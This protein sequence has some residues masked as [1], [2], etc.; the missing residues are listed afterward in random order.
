MRKGIDGIEESG[1]EEDG[2]DEGEEFRGVLRRGPNLT[3]LFIEEYSILNH[4]R[5]FAFHEECVNIHDPLWVQHDDVRRGVL[6]K[7]NNS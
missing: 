7:S 2:S 5:L 1:R 3:H 4:P 6:K